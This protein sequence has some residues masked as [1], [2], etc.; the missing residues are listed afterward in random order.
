M[1]L[2]GILFSL[3]DQGRLLWGSELQAEPLEND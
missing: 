3:W 1:D 2:E